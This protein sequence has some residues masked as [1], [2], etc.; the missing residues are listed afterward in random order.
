MLTQ[1]S[2]SLGSD[3][4]LGI[5]QAAG[6]IAL[7]LAV[8]ALCR[9]FAVH[10]EREAV[11]SMARGLVRLHIL[12]K[13]FHLGIASAIKEQAAIPFGPFLALGGLVAFFL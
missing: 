8:V 13:A 10:V 9:S 7:C 5:A 2:N 3:V 4:A 1:L 6:A 11:T 12:C